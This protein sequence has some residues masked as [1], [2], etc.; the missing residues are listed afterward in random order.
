MNTTG[1]TAWFSGH[2]PLLAGIAGAA[3]LALIAARMLWKAVRGTVKAWKIEDVITVLIALGATVYAGTGNWKFLD[4]AMHYG[5]DLRIVLVCV[6]EG[7]V[8]VEAIR[9]RRN[10]EDYGE[11]GTDGTG[12]RVLAGLSSLLSVSESATIQEALGRL[13]SPILAAFLWERLMKHKLDAEAAKAAAVRRRERDALE[14]DKRRTRIRWRMRPERIAV[15]LR[16]A[17][18]ADT[19]VSALE[20]NR[21]VMS[22]LKATDREKRPR[23]LRWATLAGPRASRA[24]RHLAAHSLLHHGDPR[25]VHTELADQMLTLAL[26]RLGITT[27]T[28]Q[29]GESDSAQAESPAAVE[30]ESAGESEAPVVSNEVSQAL[31]L[32]TPEHPGFAKAIASLPPVTQRPA[33][34]PRVAA[35]SGPARRQAAVTARV[36]TD[37]NSVAKA[38]LDSV[39]AGK[40]LSTRQ[41]ADAT[42]VSQSTAARVVGEL[43]DPGPDTEQD[44]N[45][46][47]V[48]S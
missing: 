22:F 21:K 29:T 31:S 25:A 36:S 26:T 4:K 5:T 23:L 15:W 12:L 32:W 35:A 3:L 14:A 19:E 30:A 44:P 33:K 8:V 46:Q 34:P 28:E 6:F 40:P 43:R 10:I 18:A 39:A 1:I 17:D 47:E 7:A 27:G 16:L 41:L 38:W 11:P 37:H 2:G 45:G 24:R 42:G 9:A 20:T 48:P 13:A